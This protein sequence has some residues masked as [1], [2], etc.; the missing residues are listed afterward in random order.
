MTSSRRQ[1]FEWAPTPQ[2]N[3]TR[4]VFFMFF[5]FVIDVQYEEGTTDQ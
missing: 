1:I 3:R 4:L 2:I 5:R